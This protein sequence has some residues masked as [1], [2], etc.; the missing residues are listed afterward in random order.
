MEAWF[1]FIMRKPSSRKEKG[2]DDS[3]SS[4]PPISVWE[5]GGCPT[6]NGVPDNPLIHIHLFISIILTSF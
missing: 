1:V 4:S 2:E 5:M 6:E 3:C